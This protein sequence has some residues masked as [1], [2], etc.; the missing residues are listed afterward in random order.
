ME[1]DTNLTILQ[2]FQSLIKDS[3][4]PDAEYYMSVI[5]ESGG[6]CNVVI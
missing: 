4:D 2:A 3:C 1:F 6:W 5:E